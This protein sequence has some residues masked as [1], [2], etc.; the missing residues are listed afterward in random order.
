MVETVQPTES[1]TGAVKD[2]YNRAMNSLRIV[3]AEDHAIVREGINGLLS[4]SAGFEVVGEAGDGVEAMRLVQ[5]LKPDLLLTD[6][7]MPNTDG[8][9]LTKT[10]K[11]KVPDIKVIVLTIHDSEEYIYQVF[12]NGA[13]GYVLKEAAYN[14]LLAAIEAVMGG[15]KYL[16]PSVSGD[17]IKHYLDHPLTA[18][19]PIDKL[20]P[21]EKEVLG[22]ITEGM[23][24]K[25]MAERLFVS[26]KTI[27][28]HRMNIMNKLDI[29]NQAALIRFGINLNLAAK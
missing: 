4:S 19:N 27:E 29:H 8:L 26:V 10:A 17:V 15:K 5:E 2:V 7:S 18:A 13:D 9:S 6:L 21:K 25:E 11:Q 12:K 24:N 3:V 16:S 28:F 22:L 14:E 20:T 1:L 23:S